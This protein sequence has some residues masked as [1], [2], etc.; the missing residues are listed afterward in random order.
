MVI[1]TSA[2]RK[3]ATRNKRKKTEKY[4]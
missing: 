3:R 2:Y 4:K 1:T